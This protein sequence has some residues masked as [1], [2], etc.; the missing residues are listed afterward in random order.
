MVS[1]SKKK[2]AR[3]SVKLDVIVSH[4][5]HTPYLTGDK[6]QPR[7]SGVRS[8]PATADIWPT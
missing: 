8:V 5:A 6:N 1:Y 3:C 4:S 7:F 2:G